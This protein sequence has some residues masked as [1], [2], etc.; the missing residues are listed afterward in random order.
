MLDRFKD[1]WQGV[2]LA[3]FVHFFIKLGVSPDAVTFVGTLGVCA[4]ALVFFPQGMLLTGVLVITAFVFSDLIDGQMARLTGTSSKFG[5]F[6][7]STLDR[8]G[9]VPSSMRSLWRSIAAWISHTSPVRWP[10]A[11]SRLVVVRYWSAMAA[12]PL[13]DVRVGAPNPLTGM[14]SELHGAFRL[15]DLDVLV[16]RMRRARE[17]KAIRD[18]APVEAEVRVARLEV[19]LRLRRQASRDLLLQPVFCGHGGLAVGGDATV[20]AVELAEPS[21]GDVP[22]PG[23]LDRDLAE[24]AQRLRR[25]NHGASPQSRRGHRTR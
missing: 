11:Q 10:S 1:F 13:C 5:A 22:G 14:T 2:V 20:R 16:G 3:P 25:P 21:S 7:A 17:I 9:E 4:G 6:W 12:V 24:G 23:S 15:D 8:F 19:A 18:Q